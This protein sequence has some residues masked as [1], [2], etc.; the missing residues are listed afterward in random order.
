[1]PSRLM[2]QKINV[3]DSISKLSPMEEI[4]FLHL[5]VSCDDYGRFY[6]NPKILKG[7]LFPLRD[8]QIKDIETAIR[9]L[10]AEGMIRRYEADGT[11]YMELTSW[12]KYQTPRAKASK[13]PGPEDADKQMNMQEPVNICEQTQEDAA[14]PQ[15][16]RKASKTEDDDRFET[17]WKAYPN[18]KDRKKAFDL[19]KKISPDDELY[20]RI[21][22]AVERQSQSYDWQKDGG[23]YIPMP[24]TWL[25]NERWNDQIGPSPA[26]RSGFVPNHDIT[27]GS[28]DN[29]FRS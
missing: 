20:E 5:I 24:T 26:Q 8:F 3:S 17:F 2:S 9:K 1:M 4:V 12:F 16:K 7:M 25:R 28:T 21:M 27:G 11:V 18:K 23:R 6:G 22:L 10:E 19:W 15:Q 13:Y 29:P 14:K